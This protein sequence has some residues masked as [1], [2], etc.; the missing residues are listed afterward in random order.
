MAPRSATPTTRF[1]PFLVASATMLV[2]A[3]LA[4]GCNAAKAAPG[5]TKTSADTRVIITT[6]NTHPPDPCTLL[7]LADAAATLG[8]AVSHQMDQTEGQYAACTFSSTG[9]GVSTVTLLIRPLAEG[10]FGRST[11]ANQQP[12][13]LLKGFGSPA[14]TVAGGQALV[15]WSDGL[16]LTFLAESQTA[17]QGDLPAEEQLATSAIRHL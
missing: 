8:G 1:R 17:P 9:M 5:S 16:E 12:V 7:T 10:A 11:A 13:K 6:A 15:V 2:G 14:Y 3:T 4:G